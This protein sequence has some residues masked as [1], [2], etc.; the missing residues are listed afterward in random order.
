MQGR[1][2]KGVRF[3]VVDA[4]NLIRRVYAAQPGADGPGRVEEAVASAAGSLRRA[5]RQASPSH[6]AAVFEGEGPGWRAARYPAYKADRKPMPAALQ[7]GLPRFEE[8]FH[9]E[10]VAS[11][12]LPGLEADDVIAT[13]ACKAAERGGQVLILSTDRAFLQLLSERIS[14]RDHFAQRDLDRAFVMERYGV[15]PEQFADFLALRGDP[16]NHVRGVPGIGAKTAARLLARHGTLEGLLAAAGSLGGRV[17][18]TLRENAEA[19]RLAAEL[20]TLRT[21]LDLGLN[22]RSFRLPRR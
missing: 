9:R 11:V 14:V 13:L 3:L 18:S 6:G 12:R 4:L 17:G 2:E 10:G 7:E 8:A 20:A 21:D 5:L 19:A 16:T 22:L 15:T 1:R